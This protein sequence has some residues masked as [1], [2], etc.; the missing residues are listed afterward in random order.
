MT[1]ETNPLDSFKDPD[2]E[3]LLG[4]IDSGLVI[5]FFNYFSRFEHA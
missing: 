3:K 2:F 5:L 4:G 1:E